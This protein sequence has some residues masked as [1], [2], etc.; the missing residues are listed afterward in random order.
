MQAPWEIVIPYDIK[1]GSH[2]IQIERKGG[3]VWNVGS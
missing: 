2:A 3:D 1:A